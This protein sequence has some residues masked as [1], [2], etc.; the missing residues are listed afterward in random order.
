MLMWLDGKHYDEIADVVGVSR[1]S[2]AA[3]LKR[4]R[5]KLKALYQNQ[6]TPTR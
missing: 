1:D 4:S 3:R 5:D 2:V 6:N